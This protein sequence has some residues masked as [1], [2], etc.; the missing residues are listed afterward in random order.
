MITAMKTNAVITTDYPC[1]LV[2]SGKVLDRLS[3]PSLYQ[4]SEET[5]LQTKLNILDFF[6]S[7]SSYLP[8]TSRD[9][10]L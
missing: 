5:C 6:R 1:V 9:V 8:G 10:F 4:L 7:C 2:Y 3:L